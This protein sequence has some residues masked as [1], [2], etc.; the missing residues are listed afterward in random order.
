M[1]RGRNPA[2]RRL[3]PADTAVVG[4][5]ADRSATVAA[6]AASGES[7]GDGGRFPA[8]RAAGCARE[9]PGIIRPAVEQVVGFVGHQKFGDVSAPEEHRSRVAEA[10]DD[11]G[12]FA[13]DIILAELAATLGAPAGD[14]EGTLDGESDSVER[15]EGAGGFCVCEFDFGSAGSPASGVGI[16]GGVGVEGWVEIGD[17]REMELGEFDGRDFSGADGGGLFDERRVVEVSQRRS[18]WLLGANALRQSSLARGIWAGFRVK[19]GCGAVRR[20][21]SAAVDLS[22][23]AIARRSPKASLA[24][25][26]DTREPART[27]RSSGVGVVQQELANPRARVG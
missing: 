26:V 15:A 13:G 6:D 25:L 3:E 10:L 4:G 17:A 27:S 7:R 24:T 8:A 9:I 20:F 5:N 16:D 18:F 19:R 21:E 1:A 23:A 14:F 11:D 22:K 2:R 12:V